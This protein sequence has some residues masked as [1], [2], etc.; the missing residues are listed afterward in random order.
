MFQRTGVAV[1]I[2]E[3]RDVRMEEAMAVE[4]PYCPAE[5]RAR[6]DGV[7]TGLDWTVGLGWRH[8]RGFRGRQSTVAWRGS[9]NQCD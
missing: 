9:C 4:R 5:V 7:G 2:T 1:T 8:V 6:D 3:G